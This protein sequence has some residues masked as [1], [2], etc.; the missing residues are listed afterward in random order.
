LLGLR[1]R[2]RAGKCPDEGEA[3]EGSDGNTHEKISSKTRNFRVS[4]PL[5]AVRR[6]AFTASHLFA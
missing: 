3:E 1:Q 5:D 4:R 6:A 2:C